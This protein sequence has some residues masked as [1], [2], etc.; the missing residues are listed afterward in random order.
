MT[1]LAYNDHDSLTTD[2]AGRVTNVL[3]ATDRAVAPVL[4]RLVLAVVL[5]AHGAQKAFGWFGG[6]G[7]EGTMSFFQSIGVPYVLGV[8]TIAIE[9]LGA[10]A[11]VAGS[12]TRPVAVGAIAIMAGAVAKI[13]GANGFYM[14]WSGQ[15]AGEGYELHLLLAGIAASLLVTGAGR[16]SLDRL[17]ARRSN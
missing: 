15:Q 14:N 16:L 11:L 7:F 17:I 13:H 9:V 12:L 2:A 8:L 5:F 4:L 1:S 3:F 10:A 6:Y